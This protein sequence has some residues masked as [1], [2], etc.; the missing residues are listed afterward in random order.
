MTLF[1]GTP[2]IDNKVHTCEHALLTS[3]FIYCEI[4][5]QR[6]FKILVPREV[7]ACTMEAMTFFL[8]KELMMGK[9]SDPPL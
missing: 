2:P 9:L 3:L 1:A 4:M 5:I 7:K 8:L 6:H